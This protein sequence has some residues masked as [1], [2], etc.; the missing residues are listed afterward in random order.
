MSHSY[1]FFKC[2]LFSLILTASKIID[3]TNSRDRFSVGLF[4]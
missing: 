2:V 4:L 1:Y 3:D